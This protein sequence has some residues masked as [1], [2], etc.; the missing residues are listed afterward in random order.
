MDMTSQMGALTFVTNKV[1]VNPKVDESIF[2]K[3][4]K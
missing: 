1:T 3:P 4:A 2:K